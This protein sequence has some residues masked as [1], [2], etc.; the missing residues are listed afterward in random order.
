MCLFYKMKITD[1]YKFLNQA[2][3]VDLQ[4]QYSILSVYNRVSTEG[5]I[6]FKV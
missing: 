3:T 4:R 1:N 6:F 2:Y 5:V